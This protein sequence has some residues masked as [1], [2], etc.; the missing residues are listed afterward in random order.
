MA[1]PRSRV[2]AGVPAQRVRSLFHKRDAVL[3]Q[4]LVGLGAFVGKRA[5]DFLVVVP[6]IGKPVGLDDGP[7]RQVRVQKVRRIDHS[8]FFLPARAAAESHISAAQDRVPADVRIRV[9]QNDGR[10][11]FGR[12]NRRGQP[13][14]SRSNDD[15]VRFLIPV[16][17]PSF[18]LRYFHAKPGEGGGAGSRGCCLDEIPARETVLIP[19][20]FFHWCDPNWRF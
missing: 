20:V 9:D 7:I 18:G 2:A 19:F 8:I 16:R 6:V 14:G 4:P 3:D 15:D 11:P 5:D 10:A 12:L 17:G 1:F 13:R